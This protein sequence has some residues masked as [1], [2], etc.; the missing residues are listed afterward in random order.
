VK[1]LLLSH[2]YPNL[3]NPISGVF[4]HEQAQELARQGCEIKV[5]SPIYWS[6]VPIRWLKG[7]WEAYARIP[8]RTVRDGIEVCHPRYVSFPRARFFEHSGWFYYLGSRKTIEEIHREFPFDIIHAH[9]ALPDGYGALL[10]N[11]VYRKPLVVTIHGLD[12][13]TTIHRNDRCEQYILEVVGAVSKVI[14]V[15]SRLRK[16]CLEVYDDETKFEVVSNGI[17]LD[18]IL[19]APGHLGEKYEGKKV[20]LTVGWLHKQKAHE[21]VIR[22]LRDSIQRIPNLVYLIVGDG[23]EEDRLKRLVDQLRLNDYVEFCGRKDH[24]TAMQYMSICD[25]F[26]MPSWD[27]GF[28]VVYLEAMAHGKPVI[29]CRGEGIEDVIVDGKTGLLVKPKDLESLKESMIRLLANRRLAEDMGQR[30]KRVVLSDFTWE[31]SVQKLMG[32]YR[33]VLARR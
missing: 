28:G 9:A 1:V 3:S 33:E 8:L 22:A 26:V 18:K 24:E 30:G 29:A 4:V 32:I 17:S 21:Y 10:A 23:P 14:C 15:S 7:K 16:Q 12:M 6:P 31:K 20:L 25:L 5:V 27:E 11:R 2:M 13:A 19:E